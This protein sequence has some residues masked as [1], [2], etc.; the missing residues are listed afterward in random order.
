M[1]PPLGQRQLQHRF[2]SSKA[3]LVP[4]ARR[5]VPLRNP[6]WPID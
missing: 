3:V 1:I 4:L 6:A 2:F 5:S